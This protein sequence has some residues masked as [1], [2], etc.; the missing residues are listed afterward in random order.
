MRIHHVAVISLLALAAGCRTPAPAVADAPSIAPLVVA[1]APAAPAATAP[2]QEAVAPAGKDAMLARL[3]ALAPEADRGVL[4]LALAARECAV[5]SGE[6]EA[7]S[8]LAVIDYSR[9]STARRLWVFDMAG[10]A[11]LLQH[12]YVA[13]GRGS[14]DNYAT[15]F[16]NAADSHQTSLGLFRTAETYIGGNGYSLRLDGL[17]PGVN[18]NARA[19]AIVMHG[20]WYVDPALAAKQ[21]R[22]GRSYG[23]PALR[24]QVARVVI[25]ELKDR[26]LLFSYADDAA[27]LQRSRDFACGGRSA[28][29]IVADARRAGGGGSQT[30][31]AMR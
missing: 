28:R 1:T 21:G 24:Q 7:G 16:S 19:R 25:D 30:A 2:S 26:N 17:E 12:E 9:P 15:S 23:C 6:V 10:D 22:L 18:D 4:A 27:W 20:A 13:H 29:E 31:V 3:S 5:A 8:R 14:G 11:S